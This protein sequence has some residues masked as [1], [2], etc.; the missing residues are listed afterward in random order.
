MNF[1]VGGLL[2]LER[3]NDEL[4]FDLLRYIV[5]DKDWRTMYVDG[6]PGLFMLT[7]RFSYKFKKKLP[8]LAKHLQSLGLEDLSMCISPYYLTLFMQHSPLHFALVILCMF[9]VGGEEILGKILLAMLKYFSPYI[10]SIKE[11]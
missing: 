6:T 2:Y 5:L 7:A 11:F 4:I 1:F 10:L 8:E 3:N 9:L